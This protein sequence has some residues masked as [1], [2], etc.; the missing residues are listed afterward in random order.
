MRK[1]KKNLF[2]KEYRAIKRS[3]DYIVYQ[4]FLEVQKDEICK[5]LILISKNVEEGI[6]NI[7]TGVREVVSRRGK[8]SGREEESLLQEEILRFTKYKT[9]FKYLTKIDITSKLSILS[10]IKIDILNNSR[11]LTQISFKSRLLSIIDD[12]LGLHNST[13]TLLNILF[14]NKLKPNKNYLSKLKKKKK[15]K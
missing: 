10:S 6:M 3:L 12:S 13:N 14:L 9:Y 11:F 2:F 5:S 7:E 1:K 8:W 4:E 15:K